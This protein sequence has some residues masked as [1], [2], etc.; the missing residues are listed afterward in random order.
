MDKLTSTIMKTATSL[1]LAAASMVS[2]SAQA[3]IPPWLLLQPFSVA[4]GSVAGTPTNNFSA[5]FITSTGYTSVI[6]QSVNSGGGLLTLGNNTFVENGYVNLSGFRTDPGSIQAPSFVNAPEFVG[7]YRLYALFSFSG[8]TEVIGGDLV[9]RFQSATFSLYTDALSNTVS[10]VTAGGVANGTSYAPLTQTG[11]TP[12]DRLLGS[13]TAVFPG[14]VVGNA[15]LTGGTGLAQGNFDFYVKNFTLTNDGKA[16][17]TSPS[18]PNFYN[19]VRLDGNVT[20]TTPVAGSLSPN[21]GFVANS[22]GNASISFGYFVPEPGSLML[23]GAGFAALG[24]ARKKKQ[25]V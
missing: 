18:V 3:A 21:G 4:E 10:T 16:F 9:P 6:N 22:Y 1:S 15:A 7:G 25:G 2:L 14:D 17:F 20:G 8:T 5:N 19:T 23:F 11:F 13:A 12:D 24:M